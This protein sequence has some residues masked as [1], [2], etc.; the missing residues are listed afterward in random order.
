MLPQFASLDEVS[1]AACNTIKDPRK[2]S[3][4]LQKG[5]SKINGDIPLEDIQKLMNGEKSEEGTKT[6]SGVS[7]IKADSSET[8]SGRDVLL[9]DGGAEGGAVREQEQYRDKEQR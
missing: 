3:L 5:L 4:A 1:Y 6:E 8:E 9:G 2:T 7:D